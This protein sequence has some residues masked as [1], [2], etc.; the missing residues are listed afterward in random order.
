MVRIKY[1]EL[2]SSRDYGCKVNPKTTYAFCVR[3]LAVNC[4]KMGMEKELVT[5]MSFVA[6][7]EMLVTAKPVVS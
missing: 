7:S 6:C 3:G 4:P 1:A 5:W 2:L